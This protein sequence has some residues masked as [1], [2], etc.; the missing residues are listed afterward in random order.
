MTADRTY[1][2]D[3]KETF[4]WVTETE[5]RWMLHGAKDNVHTPFMPFQPAD[6]LAIISECVA[7]IE[8]PMFLDVGSGPGTKMKLAQEFFGLTAHGIERDEVMAG[9]ASRWNGLPTWPGDALDDDNYG[10]FDLIWLYRPF[11]DPEKQRQL[12]QKIYS[13]AKSGAIVAGGGLETQPEGWI[14]I[15][16]DWELRRGAWK[17]P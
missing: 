11:K 8:G 2:W 9:E 6:F 12:E 7:E 17:K 14:P 16:D 13:E 3:L 4:R 5:H 10:D 1:L 15:I